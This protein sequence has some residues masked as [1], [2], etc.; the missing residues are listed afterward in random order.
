MLKDSVKH[1]IVKKVSKNNIFDTE[2]QL[3]IEEPLEIQVKYDLAGNQTKKSISVTMRTP[4]NDE[5][6]AV[7]FLFTEGIINDKSQVE[8]I[9]TDIFDENKVLVTLTEN[10][11]PKF[12]TSERNFYTTS[13]CGV[14]GKSSIDAI[15]TV[16][17]FQQKEDN[18]S[19]P[20]NLFYTL[21]K[22]LR[23]EQEVF[24]N[25]GGLHASAIF[26]L[27]GNSIL[28]REDVGRHNALDKV[29]GAS[30]LNEQLPLNNIIL[31]L[32]GRASFE[33]IQKASMAGIK[34]VAAIGAPSSLALQ[35]AE[36]FDITL[37]GFLGKE[38]FNIYSGSQRITL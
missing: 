8:K 33:L 14:C 10:V 1:I 34:I 3:A 22:T 20:A 5:E 27:Q 12:Q 17:S 26:D 2:D 13:S 16:S 36:D 4:G 35:L 21:Q 31:L 25:T 37:I 19:V 7:G 11:V 23:K 6:L 29:I 28:L 24:Q 18:I 32:S 15:K 30:F 38:R 9:N